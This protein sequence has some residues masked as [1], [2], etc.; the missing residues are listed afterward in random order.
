M[1]DWSCLSISREDFLEIYKGTSLED[2][3]DLFYTQ[4]SSDKEI[5]NKY[6]P[7]KLWRLNNLYTIIDK[8]GNKIRFVMNRAQHIVY[9]A[10]LKHPRLII[11]KSRQQGI[12]TFWLVS[13]FDDVVVKF[14]L[15][16]GLMAQGLDEA[17]TLLER[18]KILWDELSD[19]VKEYAGIKL[20][21]NNSKE[22]SLSNGSKIY[23]RTS[24]RSATLQRL[25]ISEMG[26]IANKYPDKARET[27]TGSLQAL[28]QGNIGVVESTAE[29]DNIFKD[30]WDTAVTNMRQLSLKD[31]YP[32]FLSWLEDPDCNVEADQEMTPAAQ[33]YFKKLKDEYNIELTRTQQN[34]WIVQH[35]ELG[36]RVFQEYPATD[37]EAFASTKEGSYYAVLYYEH[38]TRGKREI[39]NL[40]DP[41]LDVQVAFDLGMDDTNVLVAFQWW[42][43]GI[44]I[45]DEFYDNGEKIKYY[46]DWM[47][48]QPW[49]TNFSHLILPHDAE[50]R[51]LTSGETRLETF[52][53]EL[54]TD[55]NG[56]ATSFYTTVVTRTPNIMEDIAQVRNIMHKLWIDT[57]CEF[58]KKCFL[59]YRKEWNDKKE[60]WKNTPYH[61][62]HS[63]GA[64]AVRAMVV[65]GDRGIK[66]R[67]EKQA[68]TKE[69][70]TRNT[71]L[72]GMDV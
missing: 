11:L 38:V 17:E 33:K 47:K 34:F 43:D 31:F 60:K 1:E 16:A 69:L 45:I 70:Y 5:A 14:N 57:K 10:S 3:V 8:W 51:D 13:Y 58:I 64:D 52:E 32:V 21:V 28:A 71:N 49:F 26:K 48:Q 37:S 9:A 59:N 61:D 62:D 44:R 29:G 4:P 15:S 72:G 67:S 41:N 6:L 22:F 25:H 65:G 20:K 36:D 42:K 7:S 63:H 18:V 35:R 40:Y 39:P 30:M 19:S 27:K 66:T 23:V 2:Q 68:S 53:R 56:E 46:T 50:V 55:K 54:S 24:F 12:S